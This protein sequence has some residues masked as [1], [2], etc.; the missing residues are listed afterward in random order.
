MRSLSIVVIF[1]TT[2][3]ISAQVILTEVM[4]DPSG[5]DKSDE[6]VEIYNLGTS[7]VDLSGWQVGDGASFDTFVEIG[8][9]GLLLQP[10]QYG[11]I[12]DPDYFSDSSSTYNGLIPPDALILT[13]DGATFGSGGLSNNT[14]ETVVLANAAQDTIQRYTYSIGNTSGYSDEKIE[15]TEDNSAQNWGESLRFNGTPGS[16]NSLTRANIDLGIM[17]FTLLSNIFITG[18]D[19]PFELTVKNLG[20]QSIGSFQWLTFYD[21]NRNDLP[22]AD[23]I[24]EIFQNNTALAMD[25]STVLS[26]EFKNIPFG[27]VVFAAAVLLDEDEDSTNNVAAQPV[28]V[29]NPTGENIVINEIMAEP[30]PGLEEWVELYNTGNQAL[31][32][33]NI[34]FA[35]A[36]DTIQ[37]CS[38][39]RFLEP[40]A[41]MILGGD[42]AVAFQYS[43]PFDQLVVNKKFPTMNNDFDDLRLLGPSLLT[44][45]RVNYTADWYGREIEPGTSLEKINPLFSGQSAQNWAA[46]VSPSGS[47]PGRENSVFIDV[48]PP[49]NTLEITPNP[50][51][52]DGDG[53]EDF[54][55]IQFDLTVETAFISIRIFDTRGRLIRYLANG[56]PVASQGQFVWDGKDDDGRIGRIGAYI[57][58]VQAFNAE[59]QVQTEL[60]TAII[61]VKK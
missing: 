5:P 24:L 7:P 11:L 36:R 38:E 22:E 43:L 40:G 58:L 55:V 52:P 45:D 20:R 61:L 16:K 10:Q 19:I 47:T 46:S 14:A 30:Q 35:D 4:Y 33:R 54:T 15:L 1:L 21:W 12:L 17:K 8:A 53:F 31:N 2:F 57:C 6:Y 60:K 23:E 44:Y 41:F 25:D 48:L 32:L 37:I 34:Y 13:I 56:E 51:S 28:Y 59:R 27:D 9:A 26:G 49:K 3:S 42:S 50:F 18:A 39:D 29:D